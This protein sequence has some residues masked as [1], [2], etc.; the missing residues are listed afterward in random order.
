KKLSNPS[1]MIKNYL[2]KASNLKEIWEL[3]K[4]S[5]KVQL[6]NFVF[7]EGILF[8]RKIDHY[9]PQKVDVLFEITGWLIDNSIK[10]K[11]DISNKLLDHAGSV[12]GTGLEP[13]AFGL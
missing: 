2:E 12:A 9:R 4:G 7:P 10:E 13:V 6:Q 5:E 8:D 1:K 3:E 11:A